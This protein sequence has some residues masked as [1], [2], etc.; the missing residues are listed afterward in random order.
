MSHSSPSHQASTP[1]GAPARVGR[2]LV[3]PQVLRRARLRRGERG[4]VMFIVAMTMAVIAAMGIYALQMASTEVKTAG[5]IRQQLQTAYL[6]QYGVGVSAQALSV[7]PQVYASVMTQQPDLGCYSL[8]GIQVVNSSSTLNAQGFPVTPQA[9]A[10]HRA[11]SLELGGQIVPAGTQPVTLLTYTTTTSPAYAGG[12][13]LT[14]GPLGIP[15]APDFFVEVTDPTQRQPPAGFATNSTATVCFME[16]TSSAVGVTPTVA[17]YSNPDS[18]NTS[19]GYLT[20]G[21]EM[22]RARIIFGPVQCAGTN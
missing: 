7:N 16:V 12:S 20:E 6:S 3:R 9:N 4:A 14:R 18:F 15:S 5:Y 8:F 2:S 17:T 1:G 11:G 21:L 13:D 10:C 19:T 22:S